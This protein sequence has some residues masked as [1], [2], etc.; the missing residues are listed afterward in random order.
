MCC[1]YN[2]FY[3]IFENRFQHI[4]THILCI[5]K[6][7]RLEIEFGI[8]F[9]SVCVCAFCKDEKFNLLGN[10]IT[11]ISSNFASI[12]NVRSEIGTIQRFLNT[13]KVQKKNIYETRSNWM[14]IHHKQSKKW[15]EKKILEN[16]FRWL[17]GIEVCAK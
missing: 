7:N 16:C 13:K 9:S 12:L 5:F 11:S 2:I 3:F 1:H 6:P 14:T 17:I 10:L 15:S 4:S 8:H